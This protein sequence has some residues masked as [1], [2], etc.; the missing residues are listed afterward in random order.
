M[1]ILDDITNQ[2]D[3]PTIEEIEVLKHAKKRGKKIVE[4]AKEDA[5]EIINTAYAEEV[6]KVARQIAIDFKNEAI[7]EIGRF[8]KELEENVIDSEKAAE[9]V[10]AEEFDKV[11]AEVDAYKKQK[12]AEIDAKVKQI[13]IDVTKS[14]LGSS[15]DF[16]AHED[17]VIKALTDAKR[18]NLF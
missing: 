9:K 3:K 11:R 8:K 7:A 16:R 17:L 13:L 6:K 4:K 10:L 1:G 2:G 14:V 15:I 12:E 5:I 18:E